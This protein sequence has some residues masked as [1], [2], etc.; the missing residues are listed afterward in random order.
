M[1]SVKMLM[2]DTVLQKEE[3]HKK[4]N[5]YFDFVGA[6]ELTTVDQFLKMELAF[7]LKRIADKLENISMMAIATGSD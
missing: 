3:Y 7:Q 1:G 4:R 2:T 6:C 5:E